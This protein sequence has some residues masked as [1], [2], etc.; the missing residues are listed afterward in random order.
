[1]GNC[2][3]MSGNPDNKVLDENYAERI[4]QEFRKQ[5]GWE[6]KIYTRIWNELGEFSKRYSEEGRHP[7]EVVVIFR[8]AH[9][10]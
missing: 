2:V 9:N 1:M 4:R 5:T 8:T 6:V 7:V 10:I 3:V